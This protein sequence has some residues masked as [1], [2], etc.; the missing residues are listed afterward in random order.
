[1]GELPDGLVGVFLSRFAYDLP[2]EGMPKLMQ[3]KTIEMTVRKTPCCTVVTDD[4]FPLVPHMEERP[5]V[6]A[7]LIPANVRA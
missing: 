6:A 2:R 7:L 5:L 3:D 4:P 1:V